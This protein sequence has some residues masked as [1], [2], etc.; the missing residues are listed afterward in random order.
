MAIYDE[1]YLTSFDVDKIIEIFEK[2]F[3][4]NT[5]KMKTELRIKLEK[6]FT[7]SY[8]QNCFFKALN[9]VTPF[10]RP[11]EEA[12]EK[13]KRAAGRAFLDKPEYFDEGSSDLERRLTSLFED[14]S[15]TDINIYKTIY[16][17]TLRFGDVRYYRNDYGEGISLDKSRYFKNIYHAIQS[18]LDLSRQETDAL[19]EQ[20]AA[21]LIGSVSVEKVYAVKNALRRLAWTDDNNAIWSFFSDADIKNG[22]MNCPSLYDSNQDNFARVYSYV[23][24]H[25]SRERINKEIERRKAKDGTIIGPAEATYNI[26]QSIFL[27]N[28]SAF[29]LKVDKMYE[30][31]RYIKSIPGAMNLNFDFDFLF[32]DPTRIMCVDE[33][34]EKQIYAN[35]KSNI[36]TLMWNTNR[37]QSI[38]KQYIIDNPYVLGMDKA[39]F[40]ALLDE[41]KKNDQVLGDSVLFNKFLKLGKT[42]F[43]NKHYVDFDV[44]KVIG[45]LKE[46]DA[47]ERLDISKDDPSLISKFCDIFYGEDSE[48]HYQKIVSALHYRGRREE[49]GYS[50]LRTK[51]RSIAE[52]NGGWPEI[53]KSSEKTL[54]VYF[55]VSE[56]WALRHKVENMSCANTI[57][58]QV[59]EN[60]DRFAQEMQDV[61]ND[62]RSVYAKTKAKLGKK[63]TNLEDLYNFT[64]MSVE[65]EFADIK[66]LSQLIDEEL[67]EPFKMALEEAYPNG[68]SVEPDIFGQR[69]HIKVPAKKVDALRRLNDEISK[70]KKLVLNDTTIQIDKA[71]SAKPTEVKC[72]KPTEEHSK[73]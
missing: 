16:K 54:K 30:K 29:R 73:E 57:G 15:E 51:I 19:F 41:I 13:L 66:P 33:I 42:L 61:L 72:A 37:D 1:D 17:T 11:G 67:V 3:A 60:E 14:I 69:E 56:I 71:K 62:M 28:F 20:A 70:N 46:K 12:D 38:V 27:D 4:Y 32:D 68:I 47:M 49:N 65:S 22:L 5:D 7:A 36:A 55:D 25:I 35:A 8:D 44:D 23:Q 53:V 24:K 64:L 40:R 45:K 9:A 31:E 18:S 2:Y 34:Q 52:K 50:K 63:Y 26:M 59:I 58:R 6:N 21:T 48:E 10:L 43:A 39:K